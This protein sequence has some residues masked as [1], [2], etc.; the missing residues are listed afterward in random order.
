MP[1]C[2]TTAMFVCLAI[3]KVI[4]CKSEQIRKE[5]TYSKSQIWRLTGVQ[6]TGPPV[7]RFPPSPLR[8]DVNSRAVRRSCLRPTY[9]IVEKAV[10]SI[11]SL[12]AHTYSSDDGLLECPAT[13]N[14]LMFRFAEAREREIASNRQ[15]TM[16]ALSNRAPLKSQLVKRALRRSAAEKSHSLRETLSKTVL[17]RSE[18][19]KS[20]LSSRVSR[21]SRPARR[22][23]SSP[24]V[25]IF[26]GRKSIRCIS[27]STLRKS[28][29]LDV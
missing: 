14:T 19:D 18:P 5:L 7:R 17:R 24:S 16:I 29:H 6:Q 20:T 26:I 23:P 25:R 10:N 13:L 27:R 2:V 15:R 28:L 12:P 8:E 3:A 4:G 1:N 9:Q 21:K 11:G 22:V